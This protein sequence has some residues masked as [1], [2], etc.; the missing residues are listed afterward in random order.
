MISQKHPYRVYEPYIVNAVRGSPRLHDFSQPCETGRLLR[1]ATVAL[2]C[3][4]SRKWSHASSERVSEAPNREYT[5]AGGHAFSS[6]SA[7]GATCPT[8]GESAIRWLDKSLAP[9]SAGAVRRHCGRSRSGS[10]ARQLTN[11]TLRLVSLARRNRSHFPRR[12]RRSTAEESKRILALS[13]RSQRH[14][15]VPPRPDGLGSHGHHRPRKCVPFFHAK[16]RTS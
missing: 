8:A 3:D 10:P 7:A 16:F 4:C 12:L 1:R 5:R 9:H 13:R 2:G 11:S 6:R 14:D 15:D